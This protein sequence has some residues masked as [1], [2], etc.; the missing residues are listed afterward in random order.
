MRYNIYNKYTNI[1]WEFHNRTCTIQPLKYIVSAA[2]WM[3][4]ILILLR[5]YMICLNNRLQGGQYCNAPLL[6]ISFPY[7]TTSCKLFSS[8]RVSKQSRLQVINLDNFRAPSNAVLK[9]FSVS[10][11]N[12]LHEIPCHKNVYHKT[13]NPMVALPGTVVRVG[14]CL[15]RA[16]QHQSSY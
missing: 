3:S 8:S 6:T 9:P 12:I 1:P 13:N 5:C 16:R 2:N 14:I 4:L 15:A 7:H 11:P 10:V